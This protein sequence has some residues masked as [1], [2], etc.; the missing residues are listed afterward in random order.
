MSKAKLSTFE[1]E[2]QDPAFKEAFEKEYLD[3][4]LSEI[5]RQLM[6]E[7]GQSVRNLAK[8]SGLSTT[9]IQNIRSGNQ[10][11]MKVSNFLNISHACGFKISLEK[12]G[13]K[14]NL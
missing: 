1:R 10:D 8:E 5:V 13:K 14:I 4:E 2:M 11:D 12:D 9:I 7:G 6:K 3:F